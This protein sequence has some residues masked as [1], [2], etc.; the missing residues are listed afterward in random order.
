M[1]KTLLTLAALALAGSAYAQGTVTFST[2]NNT[3][4]VS[5][6][7]GGG[8]AGSQYTAGLFLAGAAADAA[9]I[10]SAPF[11][12]GLGWIQPPDN[13]AVIPGVGV[14]GSV[15]VEVR[16]WET[17]K[18]F[19][20][21]TKTGSSGAFTVGPLGGPNPPNLPVT[22]PNLDNM[23]AFTI[24]PEPSTIALGALGVGALLLR[25]RK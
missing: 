22:S 11:F 24:T 21:S 25:R 19:A 1:K 8:L 20:T 6:A 5:Q 9:P 3:V 4:S 13:D 14:N 10:I 23:P 7:L 15:S 17:G 2:F 18:T 12:D 16:A